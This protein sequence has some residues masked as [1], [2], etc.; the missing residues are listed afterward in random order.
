MSKK[1]K[2]RELFTVL[3]FLEAILAFSLGVFGNKA[4]ELVHLD[5]SLVVLGAIF[6]IVLLFLV[7]LGRIRYESDEDFLAE[8]TDSSIRGLLLSRV[9]IIFPVALIAGTITGLC[10]V[11]FIPQGERLHAVLFSVWSYE[12]IA[13]IISTI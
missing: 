7:T 6:L 12:A 5:P 3:L 9:T 10:S 8:Y 1:R 11:T 2:S 4:A 13:F